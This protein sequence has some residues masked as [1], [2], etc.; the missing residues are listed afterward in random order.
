MNPRGPEVLSLI[1]CVGLR[2]DTLGWLVFSLVIFA[3]PFVVVVVVLVHSR[4]V[5]DPTQPT[6]LQLSAPLSTAAAAATTGEGRRGGGGRWR[7][8]QLRNFLHVLHRGRHR[9]L[10][11]TTGR[12]RG[13]GRG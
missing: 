8:V 10:G 13:R 12:G 9:C 3:V 11:R 2:T 5:N 6:F 1:C 7:V 4:S